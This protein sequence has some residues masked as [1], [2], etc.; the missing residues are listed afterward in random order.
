MNAA[1]IQDVTTIQLQMSYSFS[2]SP[3][4]APSFGYSTL[5]TLLAWYDPSVAGIR[6]YVVTYASSALLFQGNVAGPF[7]MSAND[8]S[9]ISWLYP[10][11]DFAWSSGGAV[12]RGYCE[13]HVSTL[14]S[15]GSTIFDPSHSTGVHELCMVRIGDS[16]GVS[17]IDDGIQFGPIAPSSYSVHFKQYYSGPVTIWPDAWGSV[18]SPSLTYNYTSGKIGLFWQGGTYIRNAIC[19]GGTWSPIGAVIPGATPSI[20][21]G[22]PGDRGP[23]TEVL[24]SRGLSGP[25]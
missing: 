4:L 9:G 18:S 25:P 14:V 11:W 20:S 23:T 21:V 2:T 8:Y 15:Y 24:L 7:T 13:L 22:A 16:Y 19:T 12:Y 1:T 6:G 10:T 17:W 5:P 3:V